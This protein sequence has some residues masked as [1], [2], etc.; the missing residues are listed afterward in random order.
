MGLSGKGLKGTLIGDSDY[1]AVYMCQKLNYTLK[2]T[3][4][5]V[6]S[7]LYLIKIYLRQ[8]VAKSANL[9]TCTL[10]SPLFYVVWMAGDH[11]P[12][13][14]WSNFGGTTSV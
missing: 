14:K 3:V 1:T 13:S 8:K 10:S 7:K 12:V 2:T 5:F 4:H 9:S 6:V 11:V